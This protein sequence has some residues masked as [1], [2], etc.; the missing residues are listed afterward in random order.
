MEECNHSTP[1]LSESEKINKKI[2][3]EGERNEEESDILD[4][5]NKFVGGCGINVLCFVY[6][7]T[8]TIKGEAKSS[9]ILA[10]SHTSAHKK[11]WSEKWGNRGNQLKANSRLHLMVGERGKVQKNKIRR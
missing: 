9:F 7:I 4:R 11:L 1:S 10:S 5:N 3:K 6:Q 2:R 8:L